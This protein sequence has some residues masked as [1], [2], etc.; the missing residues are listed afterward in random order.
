MDCGGNTKHDLKAQWD[1]VL[2]GGI[3]AAQI[4]G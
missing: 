3:A 2:A 1:Q 4:G